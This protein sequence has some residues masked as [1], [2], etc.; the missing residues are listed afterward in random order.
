MIDE[1][2]KTLNVYDSLQRN[3]KSMDDFLKLVQ[4]FYLKFRKIELH[5]NYPKHLRQVD[6]H[7]CGA[8]VCWFAKQIVANN[9]T[10][11]SSINISDFREEIYNVIVE[12][13]FKDDDT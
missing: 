10:D 2:K 5:I 4:K 12:D 8:F 7:S 3:N 11:D 9:D 13:Y 1:T 6:S